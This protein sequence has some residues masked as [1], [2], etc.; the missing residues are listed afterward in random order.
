MADFVRKQSELRKGM[1]EQY[2]QEQ[3][4]DGVDDLIRAAKAEGKTVA[5]YCRDHFGHWTKEDDAAMLDVA[6][7]NFLLA[8][9]NDLDKD[10][11]GKGKWG[12]ESTF[13]EFLFFTLKETR[14][15]LEMLEERWA[16][17]APRDVELSIVL[18]HMTDV[19][20]GM[21]ESLTQED[22]ELY[23]ELLRRCIE[24]FEKCLANEELIDKYLMEKHLEIEAR[25]KEMKAVAAKMSGERMII[26]PEVIA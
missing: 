21:G 13:R 11:W 16:S 3:F 22:Y 9:Q 4:E 1:V 14:V 7:E 12:T 18:P 6:F 25:K 19:P 10:P 20:K 5:E 2:Q 17:H 24:V 8:V 23:H 26:S 15:Q